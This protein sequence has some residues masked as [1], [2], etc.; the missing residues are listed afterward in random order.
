MMMGRSA[1]WESTP[2]IHPF[3][4]T[5]EEMYRLL[6]V[7]AEVGVHASY[8]A[9]DPVKMGWHHGFE[10]VETTCIFLHEEDAFI[11]RAGYDSSESTSL[12]F[13]LPSERM[14]LRLRG[15]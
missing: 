12:L 8:R 2:D 13:H 1:E 15:T 10:R 5:P 3:P 14:K 11:Q 7:E 6:E 9:I 4:S